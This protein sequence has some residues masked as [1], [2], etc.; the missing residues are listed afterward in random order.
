LKRLF[1]F[2]LHTLFVAFSGNVSCLS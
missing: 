1:S 2:L